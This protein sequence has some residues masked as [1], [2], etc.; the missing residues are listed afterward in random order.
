MDQS[1]TF[2]K[3]VYKR[4]VLIIIP[5]FHEK[6]EKFAENTALSSWAFTKCGPQFSFCVSY[7]QPF[8][9]LNFDLNFFQLLI[10]KIS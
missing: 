4:K 2:Q 10:F 9:F 6:S 1:V 7:N 5:C 3:Q 8:V